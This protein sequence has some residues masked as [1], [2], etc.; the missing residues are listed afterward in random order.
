MMTKEEE[1]QLVALVVQAVTE[2][3]IRYDA[4][5][6]VGA[7]EISD[8]SPAMEE[9]LSTYG[10]VHYLLVEI[11]FHLNKDEIPIN[12]IALIIEILLC[13]IKPED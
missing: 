8:E 5:N 6:L 2:R 12:S 4:A 3:L 13:T 1:E 9:I 11:L 10:D 7:P